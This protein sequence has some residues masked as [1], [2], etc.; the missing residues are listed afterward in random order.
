LW[1]KRRDFGKNNLGRYN[2]PVLQ[3][4]Y[5]GLT[6]SGLEAGHL[7]YVAVSSR[8]GAG[9]ESRMSEPV[10][11]F[12]SSF[13]DSDQDGLPDDWENEYLG[14]LDYGPSDDP[15]QDQLD[16]ETE[17][18]STHSNPMDSDTDGD[19]VTD[20]V[21][22]NPLANSDL[23]AD[24]MP[25]DWEAYW[26]VDDPQA[27][28]D[29]D[30]LTHLQEVVEQTIPTDSD[31]DD[32]FLLDGQEATLGTDGWNPDTDGGGVWDGFEFAAGL[33][34]L[35]PSDDDGY[36][37]GVDEGDPNIP[38]LTRLAQPSPNPFNAELVIPFEMAAPGRVSLAVYDVR[39]R[40]VR[41][42]VNETVGMGGHQIRW[43]GRDKSGQ[44]ASSGIYFVKFQSGSVSEV[45]RVTLVK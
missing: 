26:Q 12:V 32:D 31:T 36:E 24:G 39:G 10:P 7:Y 14:T 19:Q 21:D 34:P 4:R 42:L 20:G 9:N 15:D 22:Q 1:K 11:V 41:S 33:D 17:L 25:D 2:S 30:G 29:E 38:L 18:N 35:D 5:N 16:N 27:D 43:D 8:D 3:S 28:L 13:A 6:L 37:S 44:T 45:K 40:L 23:D